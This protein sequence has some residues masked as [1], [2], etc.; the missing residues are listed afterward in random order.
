MYKKTHV[1]TSQ[2]FGL[3]TSTDVTIQLYWW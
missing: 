1:Q 3:I 2:N